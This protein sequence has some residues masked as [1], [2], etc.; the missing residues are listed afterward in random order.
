[1]F[2]IH[3]NCTKIKIN[4]GY[5]KII[6]YLCIEYKF[7]LNTMLEKAC[8]Y[9]V[10]FGIKPSVQRIAVMGYLMEHRTH[11]TADRIYDDLVTGMPTLSRMTVYNT[12]AVLA[13]QGAILKLDLD[14][15]TTHWDGDTTPHA[16]FI[17][18][19]CGMIHDIFPEVANWQQ[20]LASA[21]LP[22]GAQVSDT[23]LTYKG[24]CAKCNKTDNH[25]NN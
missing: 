2:G 20:M 6:T 22:E 3:A 19:R 15:G 17:C 16:H 23:Q 4:L 8:D 21:P 18:T 11:P 25:I 24:I 1:L 14:S 10:D 5:S 12:L 9:L 13:R 7:I